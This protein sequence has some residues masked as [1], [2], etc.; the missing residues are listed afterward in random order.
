MVLLQYDTVLNNDITV[1]GFREFF[2]KKALKEKEKREVFPSVNYV[3]GLFSSLRYG[4]KKMSR[5]N[6][7]FFKGTCI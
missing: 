3:T 1:T 6:D 4:N 7:K 2:L 5:K